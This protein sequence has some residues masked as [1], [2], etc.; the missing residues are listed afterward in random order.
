[1]YEILF[2][3][4]QT[5]PC[6]LINWICG[7]LRKDI[8]LFI[9]HPWA[10]LDDDEEVQLINTT[11]RKFQ[12]ISEQHVLVDDICYLLVAIFGGMKTIRN[13]RRVISTLVDI[14]VKV[15]EYELQEATKLSLQDPKV[16]SELDYDLD[17]IMTMQAECAFVRIHRLV[18][19]SQTQ[20]VS[21]TDELF[22]QIIKL[23]YKNKNKFNDGVDQESIPEEEQK[24][25]TGGEVFDY[26]SVVGAQG[27]IAELRSSNLKRFLQEVLEQVI[28]KNIDAQRRLM[29]QNDCPSFFTNETLLMALKANSLLQ[30]MALQKLKKD[31]PSKRAS[32]QEPE[33]YDAMVEEIKD[34]TNQFTLNII[35]EDLCQKLQHV[36]PFDIIRVLDDNRSGGISA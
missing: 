19:Q 14:G 16:P 27:A 22:A 8:N 21:F 20:N 9:D 1:M 23:L 32:V 7:A 36:Q 13:D 6:Y 25:W 4:L 33:D 12:T 10:W 18:F 35:F 29:Q 26:E 3:L 24:P 5:H 11:N 2:T 34:K 31:R 28:M 30:E 15:F 17:A